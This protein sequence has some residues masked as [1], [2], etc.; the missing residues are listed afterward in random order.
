[1][2]IEIKVELEAL[3]TL[4]HGSIGAAYM[5]IGTAIEHPARMLLLQNHTDADLMFSFDGITDHIPI[6][7]YSSFIWDISANK[8]IDSGFFIAQGTRI[9]VKEIDNP[10][11]GNAYLTVFYGSED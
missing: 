4:A 6:R 8:T 11:T 5:G 3:R 2:T 7:Q 1:M 10:T 9:Y